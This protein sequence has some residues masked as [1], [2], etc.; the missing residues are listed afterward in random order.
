[1]KHNHVVTV[2]IIL[3]TLLRAAAQGSPQKISDEGSSALAGLRTIATAQFGYQAMFKGFSST[4]RSL[5]SPDKGS[6]YNAAG[7]GY[8]SDSLATGKLDNYVLTYQPGPVD[9]D[10]NIQTFTVT[11][12]P[13]KR[14]EGM[15]NLFVDQTGIIRSTKENRAAT[16]SDPPIH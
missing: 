12:R 7:A 5:A 3:L 15:W 4:L 2:L 14:R 16:V 10:G 13:V 9:S 11:A 8:I 1:M 6:N